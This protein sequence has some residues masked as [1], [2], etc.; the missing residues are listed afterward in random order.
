MKSI[1]FSKIKN[2][3]IVGLIFAAVYQTGTLWL[4]NYA[5]H[6]FFYSILNTNSGVR[7]SKKTSSTVIDAQKIVVGYGNKYF[8]LIYPG[9]IGGKDVLSKTNSFIAWV[10][11]NGE[12]VTTEE[13]ALEQYI[14]Q[15]CVVYDFAFDVSAT[16]YF[17]GMGAVKN[18]DLEEI[19][20]ISQ[21]IAVPA[22]GKSDISYLYIVD[23]YTGKTNIFEANSSMESENLYAEIEKLEGL[24]VDSIKYISTS[25]SGFNIFKENTFVPQWTQSR[26][27]YAAINKVSTL[28]RF[29]DDID[30]E[31]ESSTAGFFDNYYTKTLTEDSNGVYMISDDNTVVKYYPQGTMEYFNYQSSATKTEQTLSTAYYACKEF[32]KKDGTL[33]TK[34]FLSDVKLNK[35]DGLVFCFDYCINDTPIFLS[36]K[37]KEKLSIEHGA[38]VVVENNTV[39]KYKRYAYD[40]EALPARDQWVD[41]DF[42]GAMN[43]AIASE[44]NQGEVTEI[45][46]IVLAYYVDESSESYLKWFTYVDGGVHTV[47]TVKNVPKQ[48]VAE[49]GQ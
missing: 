42:L 19:N 39:K 13:T 32:L 28:S 38:E 11:E 12:F 30:T 4:G 26:Y 1:K 47:D 43:E 20:S 5:G 29:G 17:I 3:V 44:G 21:I 16:Q 41:V 27:Q 6:N 33:K 25:Q 35:S 9:F 15:K 31:L 24:N 23:A 46:D 45:E 7:S 2:F 8:N 14:G 37:I 36:E 18:D 34:M 48:D 49:D 10:L 22:A 40:F